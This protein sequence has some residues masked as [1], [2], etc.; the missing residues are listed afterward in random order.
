MFKGISRGGGNWIGEISARAII[1]HESSNTFG[2]ERGISNFTFFQTTETVMT[3]TGYHGRFAPAMPGTWT[4]R[5][6]ICLGFPSQ[7]L[8]SW[9]HEAA[10]E[11][12]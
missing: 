4:F 7:C 6:R 12:C 8:H 3:T 10:L 9:P 1:V 5:A 2:K 11:A